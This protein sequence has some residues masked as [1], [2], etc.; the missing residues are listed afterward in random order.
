MRAR[1]VICSYLACL[2][3]DFFCYEDNNAHEQEVDH[4]VF[5]IFFI[6]NDFLDD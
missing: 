2:E 4:E 3:L 6:S 1:A 5:N